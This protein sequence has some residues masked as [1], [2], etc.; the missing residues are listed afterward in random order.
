VAGNPAAPDAAALAA[1]MAAVGKETRSGLAVSGGQVDL[2]LSIPAQSL[3]LI[4]IRSSSSAS[5]QAD[6]LFNWAESRYPQ[7][8]A[9]AGASSANHAPYY[10]RYYAG[11]RNYLASSSADG[12]VWVLG[13]MS[14]NRLLNVGALGG[15]LATA[16]CAQ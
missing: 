12:N 16:G 8:F 4:E 15:L 14:D 2:A 3:Q 9:P 7:Y 1:L 5:S 6:C 13:P 10:Y 11:T